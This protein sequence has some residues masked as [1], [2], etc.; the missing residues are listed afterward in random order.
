M[1]LSNLT[2]DHSDADCSSRAWN[3]LKDN[4]VGIEQAQE[5]RVVSLLH[6]FEGL[7]I[8][9]SETIEDFLSNISKLSSKASNLGKTFDNKTFVRKLLGLVSRK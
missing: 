1:S 4:Y 2:R 8:K 5:A 9:E 6:E 7:K 3:T